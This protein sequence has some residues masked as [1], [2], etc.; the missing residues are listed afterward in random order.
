MIE[1]DADSVLEM[2]P[3]LN[4]PAGPSLYLPD[5]A[6]V[7][8]PRLCQALAQVLPTEGVDVRE[9][10]AVGQVAVQQGRVTGVTTTTGI[11]RGDRVVIAGGAWSAQFIPDPCPAVPVRPVRGQMIQFQARP[12]LLRRIVLRDG[13]YLIPRRDGLILAGSTLEETGY[14]KSVTTAGC[15]E[16]RRAAINILPSLA[17]Y[18]VVNHWAGLRPGSP[19]GIPFIGECSEIRGLYLNAGHYRN[20]VGMGP[21]SAQLLADGLL[22]RTSF[23]G[24][25]PYRWPAT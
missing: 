15:E 21:A 18:P 11:V 16:L 4:P 20:G 24:P 3:A 1:L 10:C 23:T 13:R 25:E 5:V 19:H 6:Q 9:Q 17:D 22:G 14:D 2:E 8:N 7:R 12:G